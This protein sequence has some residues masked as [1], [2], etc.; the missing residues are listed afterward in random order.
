MKRNEKGKKKKNK[1]GPRG[2]VYMGPALS[3]AKQEEVY[4][5][6]RTDPKVFFLEHMT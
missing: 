5:A 6:K 4:I 3:N 1:V 2:L